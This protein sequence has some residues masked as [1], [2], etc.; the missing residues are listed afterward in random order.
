M[1]QNELN[2]VKRGLG[3]LYPNVKE[4]LESLKDQGYA[5]FI[6][7]NGLESYVKGLTEVLRIDHLFTA[8]Y[9]A[10]G[11]QTHSKV[12]LVAKLLKDFKVISAVM[13]GDRSSDI[14]A[15]KTNGLTTV[16]CD[17]GFATEEELKGADRKIQKFDQLEEVLSLLIR[18]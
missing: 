15:G 9:T 5:L 13:V 14:E 6:A 10:G 17:F 2:G 1:L 18:E 12:D 3:S 8:I 4:T 16:A 11:Y 7:S